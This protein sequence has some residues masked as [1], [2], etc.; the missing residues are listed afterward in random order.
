MVRLW[1][2]ISRAA[3]YEVSEIVMEFSPVSVI[4]VSPP[5]TTGVVILSPFHLTSPEMVFSVLA[6]AA[7]RG[8]ACSVPLQAERSASSAE[9]TGQSG[10]TAP[11]SQ[12]VSQMHSAAA[13]PDTADTSVSTADAG[14]P[15]IVKIIAAASKTAA[16]RFHFHFIFHFIFILFILL[17]WFVSSR[18]FLKQLGYCLPQLIFRHRL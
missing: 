5:S 2:Y 4:V 15:D 12:W 7:I 17:T 8:V 11:C 6:A 9:Q 14:T 3:V 16:G 10:L 1:E 13:F 18:C